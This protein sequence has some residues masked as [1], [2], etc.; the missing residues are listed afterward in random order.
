MTATNQLYDSARAKFALGT[1][2]WEDA[3]WKAILVKTTCAFEATDATM[4]DITPSDVV[5]AAQSMD[6]S[7][8]SYGVQTNGAVDAADVT[9]PNVSGDQIGAIIIYS[10]EAATDAQ[11]HLV[12]YFGSATGLPITPNGG[13]IIVTWDN[14]TNKIFRL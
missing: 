9:F 1:L 4:S 2:N 12:A 7:S 11:R 14:G 8:G 13:N 6:T 5:A 3:S 10:E